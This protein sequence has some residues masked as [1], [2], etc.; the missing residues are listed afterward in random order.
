MAFCF[1][2]MKAS[3]AESKLFDSFLCY[4]TWDRCLCSQVHVNMHFLH[5]QGI[6]L[7]YNVMFSCIFESML[8]FLVRTQAVER[9]LSLAA[10]KSPVEP[11]SFVRLAPCKINWTSTQVIY[12]SSPRGGT[13]ALQAKLLHSTVPCYN[14]VHCGTAGVYFWCDGGIHR[15]REQH[16]HVLPT[17]WRP[18]A[19]LPRWFVQLLDGS[20]FRGREL[21]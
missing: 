13:R 16:S 5:K 17:A 1:F 9:I 20:G 11:L 21:Q 18:A 12:T 19:G 4:M 3:R 15:R 6:E 8:P 14:R 2:T 10:E 7:P